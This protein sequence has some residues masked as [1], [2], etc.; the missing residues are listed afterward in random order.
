MLWSP[1]Y[2][3]LRTHLHRCIG[4]IGNSGCVYRVIHLAC[5]VPSF[6]S[7]MQL[8]N[9]WFLEFLNIPKTIISNSW[10]IL[11]YLL[12]ECPAYKTM[13]FKW[14][15]GFSGPIKIKIWTSS[16][17]VFQLCVLRIKG[18]RRWVWRWRGC[19]DWTI[20]VIT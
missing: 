9:I 10:E 8:L 15:L 19:G 1:P 6:S 11:Y 16:F 12:K 14:K 17:W 7:I 13:F 4:I 20:L 2:S 5:S 3:T 18:P